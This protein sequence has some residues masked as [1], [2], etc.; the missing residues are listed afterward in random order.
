M[1]RGIPA[2]WALFEKFAV[3]GLLAA[4]AFGLAAAAF[5]YSA[6]SGDRENDVTAAD[7]VGEVLDLS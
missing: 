3:R 4:C 1:T 6:W 7:A 2:P 5:G